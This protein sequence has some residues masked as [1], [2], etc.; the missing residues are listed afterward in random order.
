MLRLRTQVSEQ[1]NSLD[2]RC[3][4]SFTVA[5]W[6]NVWARPKADEAP[7]GTQPRMTRM[8][9]AQVARSCCR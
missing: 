7:I 8:S 5:D 9:A 6:R 3:W 4:H 2:C 1:S